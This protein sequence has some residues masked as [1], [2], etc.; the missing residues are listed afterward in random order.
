M[1]YTLYYNNNDDYHDSLY[2]V[3]PIRR[4]FYSLNIYLLRTND[5]RKNMI[6]INICIK[7]ESTFMYVYVCIVYMHVG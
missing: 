6:F 7:K 4:F 5:K 2:I 3:L 1:E